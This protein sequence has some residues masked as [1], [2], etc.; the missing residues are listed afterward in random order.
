MEPTAVR[1]SHISNPNLLCYHLAR[2]I[3]GWLDLPH[4]GLLA[5]VPTGRPLAVFSMA[6]FQ[7][8]ARL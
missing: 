8:L 2:S 5:A 1:P 3:L 6:N 7:S 4:P